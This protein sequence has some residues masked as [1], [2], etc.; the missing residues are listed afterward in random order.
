MVVSQPN[1]GASAARNRALGLC[2]GDDIQWLDADD[3]P[4]PNKIGA[5]RSAIGPNMCSKA[6]L[7]T[8][9]CRRFFYAETRLNLRE[10]GGEQESADKILSRVASQLVWIWVCALAG[11][12]GLSAQDVANALL[13]TPLGA[14]A[15]GSVMD[16]LD[17][18]VSSRGTSA[19]DPTSQTVKATDASG[20]A[21][22][23]ASKQPDYKPTVTS[24]GLIAANVMEWNFGSL[25]TV[26][27]ATASS[28]AAI[29]LQTDKIGANAAD[30]PNAIAAQGTIAARLDATVSSRSTYAGADTPGTTT[31]VAAIGTPAG[32]HTVASDVAAV[33]AKTDN[34]PAAPAA[35]DDVPTATQVADAVLAR[36]VSNVE[37]ASGRTSLTTLVLAATNK[38][39]TEDH[40]GFL[41]IYRT[42]GITE[43]AR[44]PISIDPTAAPI[45]G[46]G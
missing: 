30:S 23:V 2:R 5:Q 16:R 44:I 34:L 14:P 26:G 27:D 10:K 43:H 7:S 13:L 31:L 20:A 28:Q 25:P 42:D 1:Q 12:C 46:V 19:F 39:N 22:A 24:G 29:K 36:N 38:A 8:A 32:G 35:A 21:M 33:K 6:L 41:T 9:W 18:K 45:E 17:A 3:F 15:S 11:G 37:A 40:A 4:A